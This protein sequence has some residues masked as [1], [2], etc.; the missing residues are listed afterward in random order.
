[1]ICFFLKAIGGFLLIAG[2]AGCGSGGDPMPFDA[3]TRDQFVYHF[4]EVFEA[5]K[6]DIRAI[7]NDR[8]QSRAIVSDVYVPVIEDELGYDFDLTMRHYRFYR[9]E[10]NS[11]DTWRQQMDEAYLYL[12]DHYQDAYENKLIS[13]KTFDLFAFQKEAGGTI[14]DNQEKILGYITTC[15]EQNN[16]ICTKEALNTVLPQDIEEL[17]ALVPYV[18]LRDDGFGH[19]QANQLRTIRQAIY[20]SASNWVKT[21]SGEGG[22]GAF[23]TAELMGEGV[24]LDPQKVELSRQFTKRL[25]EEKQALGLAV[26]G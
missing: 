16:G 3:E 23:D 22:Y 10:T 17:H 14:N 1:M 24:I 18:D 13:K 8:I 5:K 19:N 15:Q 4:E 20:L 12:R 7:D 21:E 2:L 6:E 11:R 26:E 9:Q 25:E